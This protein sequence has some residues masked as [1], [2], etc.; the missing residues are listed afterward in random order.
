MTLSFQSFVIHHSYNL[1]YI[2]Q[3]VD[4]VSLNKL[5]N[6]DNRMITSST[7]SNV[8]TVLPVSLFPPRA[9]LPTSP[10]CKDF[11]VLHISR[12]IAQT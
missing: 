8:A 9:P 11:Q 3:T 10:C 5:S 2:K 6:K 12:I 1:F 7:H 4:K